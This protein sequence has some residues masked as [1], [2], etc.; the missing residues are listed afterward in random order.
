MSFYSPEAAQMRWCPVARS[1]VSL[2]NHTKNTTGF[3]VANRQEDGTPDAGAL[4]LGPKCMAWRWHDRACGYC[5]LAGV[6]VDPK[7]KQES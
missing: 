7:P 6:P 2:I 1:P 5:G 3:I 4:C